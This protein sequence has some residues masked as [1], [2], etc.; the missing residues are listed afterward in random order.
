MVDGIKDGSVPKAVTTYMEEEARRTFEAER[1]TFERQW[2]Y[3]YANGQ[4]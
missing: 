1:A 3:A 2:P 4:K